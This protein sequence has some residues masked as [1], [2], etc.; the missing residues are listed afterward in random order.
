[1]IVDPDFPD[2]WKTRMLVNLL[3]GDEAGPMYVI[4][5]WAHCQ[6]RRQWI[7]EELTP[8]AL[9]ALCRFPGHANKLDASLAASGFVRRE[10]NTLHALNWDEYN[11]SLIANWANGMRPKKQKTQRKPKKKAI[12]KPSISH[13]LAAPSNPIPSNP[14]TKD[15]LSG[16]E[17]ENQNAQTPPKEEEWKA[18]IPLPSVLDT[19]RFRGAWALWEK[20][21]RETKIK[22]YEPTGM[23]VQFKR[24]AEWGEERAV[25]AIE[26]SICQNY[27]GIYEPKANDS[28]PQRAF[29]NAGNIY[30]S[31]RYVEPG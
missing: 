10:G 11:A 13:G 23:A 5:L 27:Q 26:H 25:A 3:G 21:R 17:D 1:M 22:A 24:L 16:T 30:G 29:A 4:R 31:R 20:H 12:A 2:H 8:E 7:F 6:L 14:S 18:R 9:K 15:E 19:A 28:K